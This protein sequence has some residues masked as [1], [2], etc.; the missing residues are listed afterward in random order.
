MSK[1]TEKTVSMKKVSSGNNLKKQSKFYIGT[2]F[3]LEEVKSVI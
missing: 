3:K 1:T 2:E